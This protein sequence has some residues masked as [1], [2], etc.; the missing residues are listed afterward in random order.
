MRRQKDE[1]TVMDKKI[2]AEASHTRPLA[3]QLYT[4]R[5]AADRDLIAVL[6]RCA[7]IGFLGMELPAGERED[8]GQYTVHGMALGELRSRL[9]GL[10]L[11]SIGM[12][13]PLD[14]DSDLATAEQMLDAQEEV[15]SQMAAASL[16]PHHFSSLD[17]IARAADRFNAFAALARQRSIRLAYH[18]HFWE[19]E[20]SDAGWIPIEEMFA[21]LEPDVVLEAD[22]YWM[23]VGGCDLRNWLSEFGPRVA[24]LHLKDGPG[25]E[26]EPQ[27]AVGSGVVDVA[28]TVAAAP[29]VDWHVVELDEYRGDMFEAVEESYRFLTERDLSTGRDPE[30]R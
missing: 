13:I 29:Y 19:F 24:R 8:G 16:G 28:S 14:S 18:N 3:L 22:V 9:T 25:S 17:A 1:N 20:R 6:E 27:T 21:R 23:Q 4:V 30:A 2:I 11:E 10:G 7:Q 12:H 15:G 26:T 5:D